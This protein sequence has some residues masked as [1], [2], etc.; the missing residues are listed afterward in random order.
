M[1]VLAS[2]CFSDA[3]TLGLA[4]ENDF[5][6]GDLQECGPRQECG[7]PDEENWTQCDRATCGDRPYDITRCTNG[8]EAPG[9]CNEE[10]TGDPGST[11]QDGICGDFFEEGTETGC[12]CAYLVS[13]VANSPDCTTH[14][15][16]TETG[17]QSIDVVR[18]TA[19]G[20][21]SLAVYLQTCAQW[22][23]DFAGRPFAQSECFAQ[24]AAAQALDDLPPVLR[25]KFSDSRPCTC[26]LPNEAPCGPGSPATR[27]VGAD[28]AVCVDGTEHL[29]ACSASQPCTAISDTDLHWC[30]G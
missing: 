18:S 27:C 12:G 3:V 19:F 15:V 8:Y 23:T 7:F 24:G 20:D 21:P 11:R 26:E 17:Q 14:Q 13:E 10:C 2:A 25:S 30:G 5:E 22:C 16:Q 9:D 28:L 29:L 4:C 6:C 1:F